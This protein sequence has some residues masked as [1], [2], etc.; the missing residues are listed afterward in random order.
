[1]PKSLASRYKTRLRRDCRGA[2]SISKLE[3]ERGFAYRPKK[4][5]DRHYRVGDLRKAT[6]RCDGCS[7]S[8][9]VDITKIAYDARARR[10]KISF[11]VLR[12]AVRYIE[13]D[14]RD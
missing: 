4:L 7:L 11:D 2:M 3:L 8:A 1:M 12:D 6:D 5:C 14:W 10:T 9:K 13:V